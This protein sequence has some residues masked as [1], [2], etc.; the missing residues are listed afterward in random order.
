[1]YLLKNKGL[2]V[3]DINVFPKNYYK[4]KDSNKEYTPVDK[5]VILSKNIVLNHTEFSPLFEKR[6][7]YM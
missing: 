2:T 6:L 7:G 3:K 5:E 1:M 4:Y